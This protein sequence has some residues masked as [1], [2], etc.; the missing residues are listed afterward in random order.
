MP[1][2]NFTVRSESGFSLA[3]DK[4][5]IKGLQNTS[6]NLSCGCDADSAPH[7][8]L[9]PQRGLEGFK[10]SSYGEV[11]ISNWMI[12]ISTKCRNCRQLPRLG[13]LTTLYLSQMRTEGVEFLSQLSELSIK[14]GIPQPE[15]PFLS[16]VETADDDGPSFSREIAGSMYNLK[17]LMIE[18]FDELEVLPNELNSLR[19]LEKLYISCFGKL[20]SIPDHALHGLNS[21]QVLRFA[22]W[23]SLISLPQSMTNVTTLEKLQITYCPNLIL[24]PTMNMLTSLRKVKIFSDDIHCGLPNG[25]ECIP[26]LRE[27]SL[28]NFPSRASL[29]DRLKSLASLQTLKISQFPSLASLPDLLRAMTSLHT[30][31]ISDFPELTSLP[32]HFQRHLNLKKL[33]I[34]KCPGLMNRLT[35]RTGED[36]YKTAHVPKF[37]LESDVPLSQQT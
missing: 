14:A 10:M 26:S 8:I 24:Q 4:L 15:L 19:S 35:R 31:E 33:H 17:E 13:S 34:Y 20:E 25:L 22:F 18:N 29:P 6:Y 21:L 28:T 2:T 36:W 12:N 37:K 16:S 30:L 9:E 11:N 23:K 32:A 1:S 3:R 5:Y 7:Q 27:L